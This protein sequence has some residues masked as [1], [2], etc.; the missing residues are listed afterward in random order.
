MTRIPITMCHG[1]NPEGEFP[2]TVQHLDEL[3][4]IAAE[5]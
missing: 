1:I 4:A 3:V 2:L 5:L